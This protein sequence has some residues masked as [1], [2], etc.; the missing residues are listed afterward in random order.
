MVKNKLIFKE[1]LG[2]NLKAFRLS[3]GW[4]QVELGDKIGYSSDGTIS[5]IESGKRGMEIEQIYKAA[6]EFGIPAGFL[7]ADREYTQP[8]IDLIK[9]FYKTIHRDT[10][11]K[12][13]ETLR[14]IL[15]LSAKE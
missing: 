8:E 4:T 3:M 6:N 14:S 9:N 5:L 1:I 13:I 11:S 10:P 15:K 2:R 7:M 12:H